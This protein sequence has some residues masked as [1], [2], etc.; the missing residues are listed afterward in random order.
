MDL[1]TL[2][3]ILSSG[4]RFST[5]INLAALGG[6]FTQ[7]AGIWN[8][9]LEGC[10]LTA[11][12]GGVWVSFETGS[13]LLAL[14]AGAGAGV[15]MSMLLAFVVIALHAD[16]IIAGLAINLLALGGTQFLLPIAFEGFRGAVVSEQIVGIGTVHIPGLDAIPV[17]GEAANDQSP[18]VYAALLGI[19][20]VAFIFYRTGF[21][22]ALRATG[23]NRDAS[24]ALGLRPHR[25]SYAAFAVSGLFCGLAGVQLSLGSVTLFSQN[26]TAG[27]GYIA[28]AA[29]LFGNAY[30]PLVYLGGFL[31]GIAQAIV[32]QLA[33]ELA[34]PSQFIAMVPYVV[35]VLAVMLLSQRRGIRR[36]EG[37]Y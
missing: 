13:P 12:F 15:G 26:M 36:L 21:G 14:L 4:L 17:L 27:I 8:I 9:G 7:K 3:Q 6:A 18:L 32:I 34:I 33:G 37:A 25:L 29:V 23:E 30:P 22:L 28:F 16:E 31:F 20:V 11:A 5:P 2:T 19:I 35:A 10:I 24:T 1:G